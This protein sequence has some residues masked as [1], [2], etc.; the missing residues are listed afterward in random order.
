V[1]GNVSATGVFTLSAAGWTEITRENGLASANLKTVA[2]SSDINAGVDYAFAGW[3]LTDNAQISDTDKFAIVVTLATVTAAT[4]ID[5]ASISLVPGDIATRPAPQTKDE[6]LRE[7]QYYYEKSYDGSTV[8][9]TVTDVGRRYALNELGT[10]IT[11]S[12]TTNVVY[13]QSLS[14]IYDQVKRIIPTATF[15]SPASASVG[16]IQGRVLRNA[17]DVVPAGAGALGSS[18]ADYVITKW[19]ETGQSTKGLVLICN[20]TST[21]VYDSGSTTPPSDGDESM[22]LY[23]YVADARLGVI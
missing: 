18:P 7:C 23:H 3:Q 14:L 8:P 19:T 11:G 9:G 20:S 5:V 13:L 1:L 2:V 12:V 6:V 17:A 22:M 4:V 16:N 10:R 21:K 15:Y